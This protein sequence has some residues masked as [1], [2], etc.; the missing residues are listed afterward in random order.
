M[1]FENKR[2]AFTAS[3]GANVELTLDFYSKVIQAFAYV[4]NGSW[5]INF[6]P[7]GNFYVYSLYKAYN[8]DNVVYFVY[9]Y[10]PGN[11]FM[12]NASK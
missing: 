5:F 3:P 8:L 10:L 9:L 7:L 6:T 2:T 11:Y 12:R 1:K 4:A